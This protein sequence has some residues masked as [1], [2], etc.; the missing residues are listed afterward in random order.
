MMWYG[1]LSSTDTLLSCV[2]GPACRRQP[3]AGVWYSSFLCYGAISYT[4]ILFF[5]FP[6]PACRGHPPAGGRLYSP[7]KLIMVDLIPASFAT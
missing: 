2:P 4:E 5:C 3:P 6:R 7:A 1:A